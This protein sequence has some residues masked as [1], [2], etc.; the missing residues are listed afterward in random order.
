MLRVALASV[1]ALTSSSTVASLLGDTLSTAANIDLL[2]FRSATTTGGFE[3]VGARWRAQ[4]V[5][6]AALRVLGAT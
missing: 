2:L 4:V 6:P 1:V 5:T 3:T